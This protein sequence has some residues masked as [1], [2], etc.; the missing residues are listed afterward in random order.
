MVAFDESGEPDSPDGIEESKVQS[1]AFQSTE[2]MP[3]ITDELARGL[4]L[5]CMTLPTAS[6]EGLEFARKHAGAFYVQYNKATGRQYTKDIELAWRSA[7][8]TGFANGLMM[9][10]SV[11][12]HLSV[13]SGKTVQEVLDQAAEMAPRKFTGSIMYDEEI[14]S[15]ADERVM[16]LACAVS[17]LEGIQEGTAS[18]CQL[19]KDFTMQQGLDLMRKF[20][21]M[22]SIEPSKQVAKVWVSAFTTAGANMLFNVQKMLEA[23]ERRDEADDG[24]A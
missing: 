19:A 6:V 22:E 24:A 2:S 21:Q 20:C 23:I 4:M 14:Q 7:V 5:A 13:D 16:D 12:R 15:G 1:K 8:A 17:L 11:I 18:H 3:E 9:M 10:G